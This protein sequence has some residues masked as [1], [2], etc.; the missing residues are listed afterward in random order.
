M[1]QSDADFNIGNRFNDEEALNGVLDEV[2]VWNATKSEQEI[3]ES[4]NAVLVGDE[5]E[6]AG[7]WQFDE[8]TGSTASDSSPNGNDG[9]LTDMATETAWSTS[10]APVGDASIFSISA[11]ITETTDCE[12]DVIIRNR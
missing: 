8:T 1:V 6:L 5:T 3:Q 12:V 2:K 7:Y 11:D 9:T 10:T 4:M